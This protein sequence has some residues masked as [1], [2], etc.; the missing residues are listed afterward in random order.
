MIWSVLMLDIR[1]PESIKPHGL[2]EPTVMC[3]ADVG[4]DKG[5]PGVSRGRKTTGLDV[6][7]SAGLPERRLFRVSKR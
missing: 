3:I 1:P 2:A 4:A 6:L 5:K 7:Q